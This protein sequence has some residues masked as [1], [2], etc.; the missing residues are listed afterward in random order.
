MTIIFLSPPAVIPVGGRQRGARRRL[1][2]EQLSRSRE[3]STDQGVVTFT[4][5][6]EPEDSEDEEAECTDVGCVH[7]QLGTWAGWERDGI[8]TSPLSSHLMGTL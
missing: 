3:G 8:E 1:L 5:V 2:A 4:V 7:G 6:A